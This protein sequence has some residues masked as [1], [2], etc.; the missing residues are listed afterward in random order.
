MRWRGY[1]GLSRMTLRL[2]PRRMVKEKRKAVGEL[3]VVE[4]SKKNPQYC[5]STRGLRDDNCT[6]SRKA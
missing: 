1:E 5:N 4:K 2:G 3:R 6:V